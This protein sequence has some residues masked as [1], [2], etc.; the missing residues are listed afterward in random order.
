MAITNQERI[1]KA[2]ELCRAGLAPFVEREIHGAIKERN[3]GIDVVKRFADA[4]LAQKK[5]ADWDVQALLRFM[6][7]AWDDIF[8]D[9]LAGATGACS[10][11]STTIETLGRTRR[12]LERRHRPRN[13]FH[14][15][16][17]YFSFGRRG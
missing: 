8:R 2:L 17:A 11:R 14:R 7:H 12:F 10:M 15:A 16:V 13:R 1:G 6:K 9:V 5:I 4:T 3:A